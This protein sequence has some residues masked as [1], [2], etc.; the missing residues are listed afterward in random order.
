MSKKT[1]N[2]DFT[3]STTTTSMVFDFDNLCLEGDFNSPQF[4]LNKQQQDKLFL[5]ICGSRNLTVDEV[6][7]LLSLKIFNKLKVSI[8][9]NQD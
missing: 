9:L 6:S 2:H 8:M 7:W 4:K 5:D 1:I 3:S